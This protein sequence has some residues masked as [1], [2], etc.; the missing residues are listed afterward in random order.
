M[1][2]RGSLAAVLAVLLAAVST[3]ATACDASC[4]LQQVGNACGHG[5]ASKA[6]VPAN[7]GGFM[8]MPD[9][10]GMSMPDMPGM[11]GAERDTRG[12]VAMSAATCSGQPCGHSFL[13]ASSATEARRFETTSISPVTAVLRSVTEPLSLGGLESQLA[14]PQRFFSVRPLSISL[15]I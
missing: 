10:P 8:N 9:M 14:P 11:A 6:A 12:M 5:H 4:S 7:S 2:M 3:G 13:L 15:R 1:R